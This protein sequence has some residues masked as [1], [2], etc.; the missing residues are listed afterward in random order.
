MKV[1]DIVKSYEELSSIVSASPVSGEYI[2]NINRSGN[3]AV[4][5]SKKMSVSSFSVV[6][7][8][9]NRAPTNTPE[10]IHDYIDT[11]YEY[12]YGVPYRSESLFTYVRPI[13][14]VS[15]GLYFVIPLGETLN[16]MY[17]KGITDFYLQLVENFD[18][19]ANNIVTH[20]DVNDMHHTEV[21]RLTDTI[22]ENIETIDL[23]DTRQ[24]IVLANRETLSDNARD[25]ILNDN[26]VKL[27]KKEILN[28]ADQMIEG[29]AVDNVDLGEVT[30]EEL[31]INSEKFVL[32]NSVWV[33]EIAKSK[34]LSIEELFMSMV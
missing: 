29:N 22:S 18:E 15:K 11:V 10:F 34:G 3:I 13:E 27:V 25:Q 24:R 30:S 1:D 26:F 17:V 21:Q 28:Y 6:K 5:Y 16:M 31:H 8:K 14:N 32:I 33:E 2:K 19:V 9:G 12:Q 4:H 23:E 20:L 7:N